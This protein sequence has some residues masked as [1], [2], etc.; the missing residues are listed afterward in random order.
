M[1]KWGNLLLP[2]RK[3]Y[4]PFFFTILVSE[5]MMS[6]L[7]QKTRLFSNLLRRKKPYISTHYSYFLFYFRTSHSSLVMLSRENVEYQI[8]WENLWQFDIQIN[9]VFNPIHWTTNPS[10][11]RMHVA[12][13]I[14]PV[15]LTIF[16]VSRFF[17]QKIMYG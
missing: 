2:Y 1:N 9:F 6:Y 5:M 17:F 13:F 16:L 3:Q 7:K 12:L 8:C 14:T 15:L 10:E 11:S 4:V